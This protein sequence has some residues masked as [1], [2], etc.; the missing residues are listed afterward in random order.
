MK[1]LLVLLLMGLLISSPAFAKSESS[2]ED[3]TSVLLYGKY[4]DTL[5]PVKVAADGSVGGVAGSDTQVQFNDGGAFG[6]DAGLT[7]N[8]TTDTLKV[9]A[10]AK[11]WPLNET[12]TATATTT[13]VGGYSTIVT[14]AA[15]VGSLSTS[16]A[17]YISRFNKSRIRQNGSVNQIEIYFASKPAELTAFYFEVWRIN[18][19]NYDLV[20]SQNILSLVTGGTTNTITLPTPVTAQEGDY[21][22][23]GWTSSASPGNFLTSIAGGT[24]AS[25]NIVN[26]S[27]TTTNYNWTAQTGTTAYVPIKVYM[28]SAPNIV[29][30]GDSLISGQN[31]NYSLIDGTFSAYDPTVSIPYKVGTALGL[32]YQNMGV[33]GSQTSGIASRITTDAVNLSPRIVVINGGYN[34]VRLGTSNATAL[35]NW[36]TSLDAIVA[37]GI[38]PVVLSIWPNNNRSDAEMRLIDSLNDDLRKLTSNYRAAIWV[39]ASHYI[40]IFR[41]GADAGNLWNIPASYTSDGTHLTDAGYTQVSNAILDA[42]G[43]VTTMKSLPIWTSTNTTGI[44]TTNSAIKVGIGITAPNGMLVVNPPAA[45]TI[46]AGNTVTD[47]SCGTLKLITAAGA[48]TTSTTNTFTAPAAGNEGCIMH[49]CNTGANNITLDNNA[50]FKSFGGLDVV[51]TQD[52]CVTVGSTGASGVWYQLT[53]LEAN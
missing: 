25:Y 48:V 7:Y 34:D 52:D 5:V 35:S 41:T 4:N 38:T 19:T 40:G 45:Q 21:V 32:T 22:G 51:M 15:D 3:A 16:E 44:W 43:S 46:A 47:D 37:A 24:G 53:G 36:K 20:S 27:Y 23:F 39:N 13:V 29:F 6:G 42:L 9:V 8:K 12:A 50:S 10:I 17:H 30:I 28:A 14:T 1:K 11:G 31:G 2:S 49:V 26:A 18:G 33:G